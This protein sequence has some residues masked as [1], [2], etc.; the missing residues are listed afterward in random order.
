MARA[1]RPT[2]QDAGALDWT[3]HTLDRGESESLRVEP[4]YEPREP[5]DARPARGAASGFEELEPLFAEGEAAEDKPAPA[6][7]DEAALINPVPPELVEA[8]SELEFEADVQEDEATLADGA[9]SESADEEGR[10]D[11]APESSKRYT[12]PYSARRLGKSR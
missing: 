11:N 7:D 5:G 6:E 9:W 12:W 3:E 4:E 10:P 2:E 8:F 1:K